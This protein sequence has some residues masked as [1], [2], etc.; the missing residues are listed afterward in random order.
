M[1]PRKCSF[2]LDNDDSLLKKKKQKRKKEEK[3][4]EK[5]KQKEPGHA[6]PKLV[7]SRTFLL[8][9]IRSQEI[10]RFVEIHSVNM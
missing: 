8:F 2:V 6:N 9:R 5:K 10:R 3:E 1:I 7:S 4:E